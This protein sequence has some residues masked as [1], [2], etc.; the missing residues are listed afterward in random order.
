MMGV[1]KI[2]FKKINKMDKDERI[3][4][5]KIDNYLFKYCDMLGQGNFSK[6]YKAYH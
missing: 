1:Y 5:K 3:L 6:V 4:I 2:W